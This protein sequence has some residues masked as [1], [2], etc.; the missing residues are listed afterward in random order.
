MEW[1][2]FLSF[3]RW[4]D[5]KLLRI[6]EKFTILGNKSLSFSLSLARLGS[7]SIPQSMSPILTLNL[8][9]VKTL[10]SFLCHFNFQCFER[11]QILNFK[12]NSVRIV[13]VQ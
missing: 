8:H 4:K 1:D 11:I 9:F 5:K 7:F 6:T 2:S 10:L 13:F 12:T 3:K